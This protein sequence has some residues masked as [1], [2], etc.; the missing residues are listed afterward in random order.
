MPP[1]IHQRN[2]VERAVRTFKNHFISALCTVDHL[3][4]LYLWYRLLPQVTMALNMLRQS[5]LNSGLSWYKQADVVHNFERTP[6]STL[7]CKVQI[8]ENPHQWHT[9][10]PQSVD[11]W[12]IG[13][14][15]NNYRCYTCY[16]INTGGYITPDITAFFAAFIKISNFCYRDMYIHADVDMVKALKTTLL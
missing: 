13:P 5:Q 15:V 3:F 7:G 16:N 12:Y 9:Y 11:G 6:L 10:A 14:A 4:P 2:A 8:H 1:H